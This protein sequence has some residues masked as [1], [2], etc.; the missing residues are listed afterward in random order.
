MGQKSATD[1]FSQWAL[2]GKDKGMEKGHAPSVKAMLELALPKVGDNFTAI[3]LGC[4]NGWVVRLLSQLGASHVEGVDGAEEMINKA[5]DID[6]K[7]KYSHGLLPQ[8]KPEMKFEMVHSMEFLYYLQD[9]AE[10][11]SIIHDDWLIDGGVLIAGVDHYLEH[12]ESLTWP[13]HVGVHMT[14]MEISQWESAMK[15]AGFVDIEMHQVASKEG[16]PGTLV[17]IGRANH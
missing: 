8:W 1:V 13:E 6:S 5:K 3:D 17:M 14:T 9:P 10:M 4:G 15:A 2:I 12:E 16:F 7:N 11:I